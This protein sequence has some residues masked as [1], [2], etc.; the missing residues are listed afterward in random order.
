MPK[1]D[2]AAVV[3]DKDTRARLQKSEEFKPQPDLNRK[4]NMKF[5]LLVYISSR[6]NINKHA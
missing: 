5:K 3:T 1:D 2:T 4:M 6:A